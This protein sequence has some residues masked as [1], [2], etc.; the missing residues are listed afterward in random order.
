MSPKI[1]RLAGLG[2]FAACGLFLLIYLY[3]AYLSRHTTTGGIMTNLS[4]VAWISL[5]LVVAALIAAHIP[6]GAQLMHVANGDEPRE[7]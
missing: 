1:A 3:V 2:A 7:I 5:L 4:V 6:I